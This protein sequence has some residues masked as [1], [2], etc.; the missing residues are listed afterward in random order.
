MKYTAIVLFGLI[1]CEPPT[2]AQIDQVLNEIDCQWSEKNNSCFCFFSSPS[3]GIYFN[4]I[5]WSGKPKNECGKQIQAEY[6][7]R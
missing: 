1:S 4:S 2:T 7:P 6:E 3:Q 5:M